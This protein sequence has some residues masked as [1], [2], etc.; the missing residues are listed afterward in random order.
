MNGKKEERTH[1]LTTVSVPFRRVLSD[2]E[3]AELLRKGEFRKELSGHFLVLFTEVDPLTLY[4]FCKR[5][6]LPLKK[7]KEYYEAFIKPHC[8]NPQLEEFFDAWKV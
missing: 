5:Y 1:Y 4:R 8:R 7:L 6:G 3:I 2:E